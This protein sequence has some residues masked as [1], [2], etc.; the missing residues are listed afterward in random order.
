MC[1][2]PTSLKHMSNPPLD[3]ILFE[4]IIETLNITTFLPIILLTCISPSVV[5][6]K[7]DNCIW[8]KNPMFSTFGNYTKRFKKEGNHQI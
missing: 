1:R 5:F 3:L 6:Q 7:P 2:K 4:K 8:I